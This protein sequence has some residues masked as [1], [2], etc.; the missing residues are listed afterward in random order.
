MSAAFRLITFILFT[1]KE[2]DNKKLEQHR[3][4]SEKE[5]YYRLADYFFVQLVLLLCG[6]TE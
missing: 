5:K 4:Y 1:P 6:R 2:Y 3:G